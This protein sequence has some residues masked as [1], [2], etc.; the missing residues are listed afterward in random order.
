MNALKRRNHLKSLESFQRAVDARLAQPSA[1]RSVSHTQADSVAGWSPQVDI[2]EDDT[3][4]LIKVELFEMKNEHVRVT[5]QEGTLS[6]VGERKL[7]T[8]EKVGKHPHVARA[9]G[10]FGLSFSLPDDTSP[11]KVRTEFKDGLLTVHLTKDEEAKPLQVEAKISWTRELA[12][13]SMGLNAE[14]DQRAQ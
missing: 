1:Q 8:V 14:L 5:A 12:R 10:T 6:I 9:C 4:Y 2:S 13:R 11:G 7:E 3:E